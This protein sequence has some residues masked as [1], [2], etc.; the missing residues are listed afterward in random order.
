[1]ETMK[2]WIA[3]DKDGGLI[4]SDSEPYR[5]GDYYDSDGEWMLIKEGDLIHTIFPTLTFQ[6]S[7]QQV[8]LKLIGEPHLK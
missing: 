4:I 6:N 2:L 8:E 3:S 7:P 5:T 1:M